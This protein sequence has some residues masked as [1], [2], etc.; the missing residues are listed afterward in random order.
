MLKNSAFPLKDDYFG[1][2][3]LA[4][5]ETVLHGSNHDDILIPII[6]NR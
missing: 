6:G 1:H 4:R 2:I 3:E 5:A